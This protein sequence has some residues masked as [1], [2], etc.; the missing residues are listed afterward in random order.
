MAVLKLNN[1][2]LG[3]ITS[4]RS[5]VSQ[6]DLD[7]ALAIVLKKAM[8]I[9]QTK[10]GSIALYMPETG[11]MRIQAHKGFSRDF[12]QNREWKARKG[13]L[14]ERVLKSRTLTVVSS[15]TNR[16]FF[17]NPV[18]VHEGIKS[19]ICVPLVH[20]HEVVG[21]L[22]VDDFTSRKFSASVLQSLKILG[23]FA[24]IAIRHA[25]THGQVKQLAITDGLTG[26]FNRRYFEDIL[27]REFQRAS[28]HRR[29]FSLALVD[30]DDFKKFNDAY[31]HQAGDEAL[32]SLGEAIRQSIRSTDLAARYGG[33]EIVIILPET[34][35]AKAYNLFANRVKRDIEGRFAKLSGGRHALTVTIGIASYPT[36]GGNAM[37]LI[38]SADKAMLAAKKEKDSPRIGCARMISGIIPA[39]P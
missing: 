25:R 20:S 8:E 31:G 7:R 12:I 16:S 2:V 21:I 6:L 17:N 23:S 24:S 3:L 13:G 30:V 38:L 33:D 14:T 37:D 11:T 22:Y 4:A 15:K 39:R 35:L 10:A 5:I 18:A 9:T 26:L 32:T 19:L 34:K 28:R 36:D 1:S 29:E 27:S